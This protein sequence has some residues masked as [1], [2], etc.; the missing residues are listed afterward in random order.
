MPPGVRNSAST[1]ST[2]PSSCSKRWAADLAAATARI[3]RAFVSRHEVGRVP[4]ARPMR[5]SGLPMDTAESNSSLCR[6]LSSMASNSSPKTAGAAVKQT[7]KSVEQQ[8]R[9]V[10]ETARDLKHS[11][12]RIETS[13]DRTTVLAAD[14]NI[15]ASERTY[16]AWVRTGLLALAGGI[17]ARALRDVPDWLVLANGTLLIAFS[18]FCF[19]AAV[20]R[21]FHPGPPPPPPSVKV[22]PWPA[23]VV[24]NGVL[25][26]IA[27]GALAALWLVPRSG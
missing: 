6:A 2:Q 1:D 23:L 8:T 3:E 20:W 19:G 4:D 24:A 26:V 21:H 11:S 14:R 17:G 7:A 10:A 27:A 15:L 12:A 13:A 18:L 9:K 5:H 22:M 25:A 16:A